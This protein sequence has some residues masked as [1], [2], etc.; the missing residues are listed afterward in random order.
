MRH[1]ERRWRHTR[2]NK[3][4]EEFRDQ[5]N[6]LTKQIKIAKKAY[7][8]NK[9]S[10]AGQTQKA[11]FQCVDELVRKTKSTTFP[12]NLPKDEQPNSFKNFFHE[13]IEKLQ[14][15]FTE[16]TDHSQSPCP[17]VQQLQTFHPATIDEIRALIKKSP[18][19]S[20]P[21][22]PIPTFLLKDCLEELLP[23]ITTIIKAYLYTALVPISFKKAVVTPLLKKQSLEPDVLGNYRPVSNLSFISKILEKVVAKCLSSHKSR[24]SLY[25]PF[26]SA[27]RA[28]HSMETAVVRVQNDILEAIDGG[29]CVFLVLLDLS[30]A[31][32]TVSHDILLDRLS[33]DSGISGSALSWISSYLANRTQSVLVSGKYS[34]SAHLRYGVLQGSVLGPALFSDYSFPVASLIRSFEITAHCYADDTQ[35]YVPFTPG[36]DEEDVRNKLEDCI[37]ALRVW[38]NKTRLT[39]NDKKTEFIIFSTSARLKKI[40][41]TT[42]RVGQ[43]AIPACDK[44]RNIGAMFDS[45]MKMDTQVNSMCKSAWFHLYTIG[46]IRS[47]LS[48]DQTKSVVHAYVTPKLDGNNAL[49]VGPRREYLIDK[50]QLVQN[51]AAKIITKLKKFDHVTPLLRQL[52]WLPISKRITFKVL[53]LVYKSLNDMGPV[54]LRD[55]LIYYKPKCE[56]LRHDPLSLEVPGTELVTYGDRTFRVVAAKA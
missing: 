22:D 48:E 43:E 23:A 10:S 34:D 31:F 5:K 14:P 2:E 52:H 21:L 53:L 8:Q 51:A 11:L 6:N 47:H 26:Q 29:K 9:I 33:T 39:L 54:Y 3:H 50:L 16:S 1:A 42:I 37:D 25:E 45:E 46:K 27:Y 24:E 18:S 40:A 7:Y 12:S 49:L 17:T 20:C 19:K 41:A 44:V 35:L 38:M 4:W 15:F 55:L 28:G 13:K 36:I 56:G 32:D 30:A